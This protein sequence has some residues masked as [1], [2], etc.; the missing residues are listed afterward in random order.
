MVSEICALVHGQSHVG[1]M[2][3]TLHNCLDNSIELFNRENPTN[4][5][6]DSHSGWWSSPYV[7]VEWATMGIY[8]CI[9]WANTQWWCSND[10][11]VIN[12]FIANWD[13]TCIRGLR[14]AVGVGW[15]DGKRCLFMELLSAVK[16]EKTLGKQILQ[17][18]FL[19]LSAS[20]TRPTGRR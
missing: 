8:I 10:I 15:T 18:Q 16:I 13:A 1:Q 14:V 12:N 17:T 2:H 20:T 4:S 9:K 5:F 11:W 6:R 19:W 7:W 3:K